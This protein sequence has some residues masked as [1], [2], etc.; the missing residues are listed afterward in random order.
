MLKFNLRHLEEHALHL[1]GELPVAELDFGVTDELIHLDKPLRY[2]LQAEDM[3][4]SVLVTGSLR[5][6]LDCECARCLKPFQYEMV[7][8]G[9]AVHL[10][11]EGEDAVSVDNDCVDLT[12]FVREDMLL[13]FPQHPLCKPDCAGLKKKVRSQADGKVE[14]KPSGWSDLDKLKL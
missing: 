13:E 7:L 3:H 6:A 9:W 4:E 8:K 12:P 1:K 14:K 10:P 5:L 2:D 11:L